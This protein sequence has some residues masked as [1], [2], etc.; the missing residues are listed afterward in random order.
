MARRVALRLARQASLD[1]AE[2]ADLFPLL[3][4]LGYV[5]ENAGTYTALIPVLGRRDSAMTAALVGLSRDVMSEWL[6]ANYAKM[7]GDLKHLTTI[8]AGLP[9]AQVYTQIWHY[10]FGTT[11]RKLVEAGLFADPYG[12]GRTYQGFVP[13]VFD[14]SLL[15]LVKWH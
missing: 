4:Q 1:S 12:A 7:E 3:V 8:R 13:V 15:S 2:T 10:L 14:P 6:A 5:R 11:N 9:Y